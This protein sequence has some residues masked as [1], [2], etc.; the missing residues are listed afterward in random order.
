MLGDRSRIRQLQSQCQIGRQILKKRQGL[1]G[2]SQGCNF[3]ETV[4]QN[5]TAD[6]RVMSEYITLGEDLD[7]AS[8]STALDILN[9]R[10]VPGESR[11]TW[12][13]EGALHRVW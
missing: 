7:F 12:G 11:C 5:H 10:T 1:R 9:K 4:I 2:K 8:K 13:A 6:N 3:G